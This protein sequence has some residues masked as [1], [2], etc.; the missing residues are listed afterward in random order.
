M[1]AFAIMPPTEPLPFGSGSQQK[2]R[3]VVNAKWG[4]AAPV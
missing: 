1:V 2:I 3:P 4:E